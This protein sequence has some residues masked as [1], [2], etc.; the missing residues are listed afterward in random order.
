[1]VS[2][3]PMYVSEVLLSFRVTVVRLVSVRF[4]TTLLSLAITICIRNR[5]TCCPIWI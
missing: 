4:S 3:C 1:M 2:V 5:T